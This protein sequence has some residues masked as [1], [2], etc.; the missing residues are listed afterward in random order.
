MNDYF[1]GS[2]DFFSHR[3]LFAFPFSTNMTLKA[4]HQCF[5]SN[6]LLHLLCFTTLLRSRS[7]CRWPPAIAA[8]EIDIATKSLALHHSMLLLG[9]VASVVSAGQTTVRLCIYDTSDANCPH[10]STARFTIHNWND[11]RAHEQDSFG[12]TGAAAI[13]FYL[14][15]DLT[16]STP[17]ELRLPSLGIHN[18]TFRPVGSERRMV[19]LEYISTSQARYFRFYNSLI[20]IFAEDSLYFYNLFLENS[21]FL[22]P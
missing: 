2:V 11:Y 12:V 21:I 10:D 20:N 8:D 14:L 22:N 17:V 7:S 19:T 3:S 4:Y 6:D 1:H 5:F 16:P 18:V 13:T 9:L 15:A